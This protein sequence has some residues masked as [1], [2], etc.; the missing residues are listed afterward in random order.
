MSHVI[1]CHMS[2][3]VTF[4]VMSCHVMLF[5]SHVMLYYVTSYHGL[6]GN[7]DIVHKELLE[8]KEADHL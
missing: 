5:H 6:S 2:C 1:S 4:H 3:H 8:Q 7:V